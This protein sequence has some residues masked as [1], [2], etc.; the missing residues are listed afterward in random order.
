MVLVDKRSLQRFRMPQLLSLS[1]CSVQKHKLYQFSLRC[2][3]SVRC[4]ICIILQ[5]AIIR[6][7][8]WLES[9]LAEP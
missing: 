6:L 8:A 9:S 5:H 7:C 3:M 4:A 1:S 2:A